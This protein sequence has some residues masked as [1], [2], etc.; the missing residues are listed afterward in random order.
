MSFETE[1]K[2][3]KILDQV[4]GEGRNG[5]WVKQEFVI[6]TPG[7]YPKTICFSL[8]GEDKVKLITSLPEGSSVKV[9]FDVSSREFKG[10]WYTELRA[11]KV[12]SGSQNA[13]NQNLPPINEN[14]I[15][16]ESEGGDD[17]PF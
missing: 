16:P 6:E 2:L 13:N 17:L 12:Q 4:S 7:E 3:I 10:R 1:G 11:W 5:R 15:P 9:S 14:D 8:W